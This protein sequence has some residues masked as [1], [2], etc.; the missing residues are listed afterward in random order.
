L[1]EE[2]ARVEAALALPPQGN[3][4]AASFVHALD[5]AQELG[6]ALHEAE[7][8]AHCLGVEQPDSA[9]VKALKGRI[10]ELKASWN[11]RMVKLDQWMMELSHEQWQ[12]VLTAP[13]VAP[14]A[15]LMNDRRTRNEQNMEAAR[16]HLVH[17]LSTDGY[18]AWGQLYFQLISRLRIPFEVDGE[19]QSLTSGQMWGYLVC[20]DPV[21]R[22]KA[23]DAMEAAFAGEAELIASALNHLVGFRLNVSRHRGLS[24][25]L[26]ETFAQNQ[27]TEA[28]LDAMWDV[29]DRSTERLTA[30]SKRKAELI[31]TGVVSHFDIFAPI[32]DLNMPISY[33]E[34]AERIVKQFTKISAPMG[35]FAERAFA[36]GW[37]D[38]ELRPGKSGG[39]QCIPF[40]R[41]HASRVTLG[42]QG[43]AWSLLVLAHELGHGYHNDAVHDLP[44]LARNYPMSVAETA[45]TFAE[46]VVLDSAIAEAG[47]DSERLQLLGAKMQR[48]IPL[49]LGVRGVFLFERRLHEQR[50]N[51][52]LSVE[53]LCALMAECQQTAFKGALDRTNP[54]Q[55]ASQGQ[56]Y[57]TEVP[58]YSFQYTFGYLFSTG[59]YAR[60]LQEGEA[61]GDK[62]AALLRDTGRMS[63]EDLARTHL[64]VDLTG[65]EFWQGAMDLL[66]RDVEQFL[67]V[68]K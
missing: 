31:G 19:A 63:V 65:P 1:A 3:V 34:A 24:S 54:Y 48:I 61:F 5:E 44:F 62:Y 22:A 59:L 58:F 11:S 18:H 9:E 8:F 4:T 12:A 45:S 13:S 21:L 27:L 37:I 43:T 17:D 47:S 32:G 50:K 10:Q 7:M 41:R 64:G 46:M 57:A 35:Q 16:E 26:Q 42:Y 68:S 30:F 33:E 49:I 20:S 53:E 67:E 40:H 52:P 38:A 6:G 23:A 29:V 36:E 66:I 25:V 39:G 56:I 28:T 60:A 14:I 55:W 2:L 15:Y 51:G